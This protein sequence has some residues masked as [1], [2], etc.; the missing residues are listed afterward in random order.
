MHWCF[1]VNLAKLL[2]TL[3]LQ[4]MPG[5]LLLRSLP[6]CWWEDLSTLLIQRFS[7]KDSRKLELASHTSKF[8]I[9]I[10]CLQEHQITHKDEI[11]KELLYENVI[12]T[13]S[14]TKSSASAAIGGVGFLL[15]RTANNSI[16]YMEKFTEGIAIYSH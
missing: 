12:L 11:T 3:S 15:S 6:S 7:L 4:N 5:R 8:K 16:I 1:P 14:A 2:R 9:D 10:I 13:C